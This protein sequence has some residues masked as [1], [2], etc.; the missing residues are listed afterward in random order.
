MSEYRIAYDKEASSELVPMYFVYDTKDNFVHYKG[1][2]SQCLCVIGAFSMNPEI[3][4]KEINEK[5]LGYL[6]SK[7]NEAI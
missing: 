3:T 2:Y 4:L 5:T 7:G 6:D 1:T